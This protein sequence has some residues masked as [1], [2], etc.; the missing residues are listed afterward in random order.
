MAFPGSAADGGEAHPRVMHR[1]LSLTGSVGA[2]FCLN[3]H[4][5][6]LGSHC[7]ECH[8]IDE[9]TKLTE[10]LTLTSQITWIYSQEHL[11][12]GPRTQQ[13]VQMSK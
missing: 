6:P 9:M 2:A 5:T 10:T 7:L 12:C 8:S 13:C 4:E 11:L 1:L 3:L